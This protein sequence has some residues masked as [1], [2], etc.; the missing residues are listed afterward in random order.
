MIFCDFALY[1]VLVRQLCFVCFDFPKE[2]WTV[3]FPDPVVSLLS[4]MG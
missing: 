2:Q 1:W 4:S 3:D